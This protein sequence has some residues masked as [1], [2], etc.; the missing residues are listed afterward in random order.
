MEV[1]EAIRER[2]ATKPLSRPTRCR[3]MTWCG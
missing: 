1:F 2:F 3:L